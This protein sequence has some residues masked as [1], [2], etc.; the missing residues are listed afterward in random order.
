MLD[1]FLDNDT[2][3]DEVYLARL[4]QW[5]NQKLAASDWTQLPDAVCDKAAWATYRQAL[6]N[7][8]ASNSD[9]KKVIFPN[10]PDQL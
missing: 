9:P 7:M 1:N 10:E 5:R 3:S 8:P 6:R 2:V 4:R